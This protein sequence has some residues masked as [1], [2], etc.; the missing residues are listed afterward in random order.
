MIIVMKNA[1]AAGLML[2]VVSTSTLAAP[3]FYAS[4]EAGLGGRDTK[5]YAAN[6]APYST[7][8][9]RYGIA[10][11]G[12]IGYLFGNDKWNYGFEAGYTGIPNNVYKSDIYGN[13]ETYTGFYADVLG[14]GKYNFIDSEAGF[15]ITGKAGAAIVSQNL[16]VSGPHSKQ[17]YKQHKVKPEFAVG[18]GYNINKNLAVEITFSHVFGSKADPNAA[19]VGG[20]SRASPS[21]T[22]M[23]GITYNFS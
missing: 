9:L 14:V 23:A 3:G 2:A 7:V 13:S 21:N 8:N 18:A 20:A 15:F 4:A 1:W 5:Q 16:I 17:K 11:R 22:L 12:A 10:Y 6:N 19:T